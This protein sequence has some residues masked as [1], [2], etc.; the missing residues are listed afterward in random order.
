MIPGFLASLFFFETATGKTLLR[1]L[2][3]EVPKVFSLT[4]VTYKLQ[5]ITMKILMDA[6]CLIKLTK[7]GLKEF[8]CQNEKIVIPGIV[9]REVVDAGKSKGHPDAQLVEENIRHGLITV[10]KEVT[11]KHVKGDQALVAMFKRGRYTAVA[12]DDAKL[13]R[14][15]R[16]TEIPFVLPALLIYSIY[17][18]GLIDQTKGL[19]W[20][21]RLSPFINEEEYS[22][23]K[24]LLEERP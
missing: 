10:V 9:K 14:I 24:L 22:V 13:I 16:A 17:C 7:A 19:N 21:D 3:H 2:A 18:R 15:L 11:L 20:L 6:D 12:T 1:R 5:Y 23:T 4:F 8:I